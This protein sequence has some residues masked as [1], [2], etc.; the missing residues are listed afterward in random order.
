MSTVSC[1]APSSTK[2]WTCHP[3]PHATRSKLLVATTGDR[4][5][6]LPRRTSGR[7]DRLVSWLA[8][9]APL[10]AFP[11]RGPWRR[12]SVAMMGGACRLQLRG[13]PRF[14]R[15]AGAAPRSLSGGLRAQTPVL[16]ESQRIT[17][18]LSTE[19][20][21]NGPLLPPNARRN[22]PRRLRPAVWGPRGSPAGDRPDTSSSPAASRNG[23]A[24]KL[25]APPG[26]TNR[27][28]TPRTGKHRTL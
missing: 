11:I 22:R 27:F 7:Q 23:T 16:F 5:I 12:I 20:V 13:Q 4:S 15:P 21:G 17:K 28:A 26:V 19:L 9:L 6:P 3:F 14:W 2:R 18:G 10:S 1:T 8:A 25:T 24:A